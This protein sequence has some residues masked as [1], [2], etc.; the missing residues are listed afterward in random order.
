MTSNMVPL[1]TGCPAIL[2]IA[3]QTQVVGAL[4]AD[5]IVAQV[6][7]ESFGVGES[8]LAVDPFTFVGVRNVRSLRLRSPRIL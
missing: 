2:P 3:S 4:A 7:I 1:C 8:F 5:M 6:A